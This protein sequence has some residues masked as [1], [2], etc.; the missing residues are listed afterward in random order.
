MQRYLIDTHIYIWYAKEREN[1]SRDVLAILDDYENQIYLSAESLRVFVLLWNSK[2]H[3]RRWWKSPM[4]MIRSVEAEAKFQIIISHA[5]C[6]GIPLISD[7]DKFPFY[8]AQGL[9]LI[10]N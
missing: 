10:E 3:I 7:D 8:R 1:L 4:D 9:E 2:P 6:N 5:L